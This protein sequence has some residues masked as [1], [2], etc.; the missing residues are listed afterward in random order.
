MFKFNHILVSNMVQLVSNIVQQLNKFIIQNIFYMQN[1]SV[2]V[3][4]YG[5]AKK[6][7]SN[8]SVNTSH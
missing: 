4:T 3:I 1:N 6:L 2:Y 8:S 7:S 5:H